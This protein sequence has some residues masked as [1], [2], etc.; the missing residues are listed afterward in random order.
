[1]H[2]LLT[3]LYD[4]P[5]FLKI[6]HDKIRDTDASRVPAAL[7]VVEI[8]RFRKINHTYGY[9]VGDRL[10][11]A[12]GELLERVRRDCDVTAR[13]GNDCFALLLTRIVN[14]GHAR[15]A[16]FK[17]LQFLEIPFEIGDDRV[18]G[19]AVV[20]V[21]L[22]PM[23]ST[24]PGCLLQMAEDALEYAKHTGQNL[25]QLEIDEESEISNEWDIEYELSEA[26]ER[27]ELLAFLQPKVSIAGGQLKPKGAEALVRWNSQ[28]RGIVPP[29]VFLPIAERMG[30]IKKLTLWM[31]NSALKQSRYWTD[32]W[33]D[34]SVSVNVPPQLVSQPD[35]VDLVLSTKNIWESSH[36]GLCLEIVEQ[37]MVEDIDTTFSKLRELR[38]HGIRISIDDF[39]T[40]YSSLAYFRDIPADELKIDRSFVRTLATDGANLNIVALIIDLAHR[41]DLTVVAEGVEDRETLEILQGL[42]CDL[43]QG[44]YFS[45]PLPPKKFARWLRQFDAPGSLLL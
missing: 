14:P 10:L 43:V 44:Y 34:L 11:Q 20:G 16:A 7:L 31:L 5:Q 18:R 22:Y 29:A 39:G 27:S 2:D 32:K 1:M 42:D 12:F 23:H 17:I 6:L 40:G 37:S 30:L 28:A 25:G 3:G 41:F 45:K 15:L 33:G 26:V 38:E 21:S 4:R 8:Q 35:F 24:H 36:V 13:I 19:D 9:A